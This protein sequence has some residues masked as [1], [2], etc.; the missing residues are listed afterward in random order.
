MKDNTTLG[1]GYPLI[2]TV[3][4]LPSRARNGSY[5]ATRRS[6]PSTRPPISR[7]TRLSVRATRGDEAAGTESVSAGVPDV[8]AAGAVAAADAGGGV[9][10]ELAGETGAPGGNAGVPACAP[11]VA[12]CAAAGGAPG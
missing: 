8:A 10:A 7:A 6:G 12:G 11:P 5:S 9:G 4:G 3:L 1:A 2:Q